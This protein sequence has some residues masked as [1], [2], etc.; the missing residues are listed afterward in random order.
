MHQNHHLRYT[1]LF[2]AMIVR[3]CVL[4]FEICRVFSKK[5]K[6]KKLKLVNREGKQFENGDMEREVT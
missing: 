6:E 2:M 4:I 5:L 1:N 3:F